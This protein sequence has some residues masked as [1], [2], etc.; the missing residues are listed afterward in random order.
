MH[1]QTCD[2]AVCY[3]GTNMQCIS[4]FDPVHSSYDTMWL[5]TEMFVAGIT[6]GYNFIIMCTKCDG[7]LP[8]EIMLTMVWY[9]VAI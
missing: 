9:I 6:N 5:Y 3:W 7:D 1:H 2:P 8:Y 4:D